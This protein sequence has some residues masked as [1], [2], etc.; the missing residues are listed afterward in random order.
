MS[1]RVPRLSLLARLGL[2]GMVGAAILV[3]GI[4]I[5]Q[6]WRHGATEL[7]AGPA[8][9]AA[10]APVAT[11]PRGIDMI[12]RMLAG[13]GQDKG[14][15]KRLADVTGSIAPPQA[16]KPALGPVTGL[17][18]P[19]FVS[20][21]TDRVNVRQGPTRDQSVAFI[22]Q[23]AGLPIEVTAE[24]ENWRRIRDSEGAEGWVLQNLVSG[25]RT[26]LVSPWSKEPSLTLHRHADAASPTVARLQPGVLG[27]IKTC[28]GEWCHIRGE[29]FDGWIEQNRLWGA[30][31]GE[32]VD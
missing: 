18:I 9:V 16:P 24:F 17:P 6:R 21:K 5:H 10:P 28:D 7:P 29:G 14:A 30:Y 32:E 31:P 13:K 1:R 19:R 11:Q 20:L 27:S 8:T 2:G 22:F 3:A 23:R 15:D 26:A 25:R 4:T 12:G